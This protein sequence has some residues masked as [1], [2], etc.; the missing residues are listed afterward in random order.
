MSVLIFH[1]DLNHQDEE[2]FAKQLDEVKQTNDNS[3][4]KVLDFTGLYFTSGM[5][6]MLE[7]FLISDITITGISFHRTKMTFAVWKEI[8]A[9]L[10]S[11]SSSKS[12]SFIQLDFSSE[13]FHCLCELISQK[14]L[15]E[16]NFEKITTTTQESS[17][18]FRISDAQCILSAISSNKKLREVGIVPYV[19]EKFNR[20]INLGSIYS[21]L[22]S[23]PHIH[24]LKLSLDALSQEMKNDIFWSLERNNTLNVLE[25]DIFYLKE[26]YELCNS[27]SNNHCL[28][29]IV[30]RFPY[31]S[32]IIG[33]INTPL[34]IENGSV[35]EGLVNDGILLEQI[36]K[37]TE[38]NKSM[39]KKARE[40]TQT[41]LAIQRK[42]KNHFIFPKD[43]AIM[44]GKYLLKTKTD[45]QTWGL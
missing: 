11:H 8:A 2:D 26:V 18:F 24:E 27:L 19:D 40:A 22:I 12:L 38:R 3:D 13:G 29:K 30:I 15:V 43:M 7:N 1:F 17:C 35:T 23:L 44:L 25:L 5:A 33:P 36:F 32:C 37:T 20:K 34:L 39:H 4:K 16:L 45:I 6:K 14:D 9:C 10:L 42:F 31:S 21:A 28:R 41:I